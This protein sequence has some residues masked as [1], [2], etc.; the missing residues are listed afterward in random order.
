MQDFPEWKERCVGSLDTR[1]RPYN[2]FETSLTMIGAMLLAGVLHVTAHARSQQPGELV[3]LAITAPVGTS[4]IHVRAFDR[5][6]MSFPV[7]DHVWTALVGID[8]DVVPGTH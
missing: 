8:L 3:V 6:V 7:N 4:A 1:V 5:D 2:A